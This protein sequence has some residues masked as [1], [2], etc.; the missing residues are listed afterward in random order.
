MLVCGGGVAVVAQVVAKRRRAAH[1]EAERE[2]DGVRRLAE[3]DT[4]LFGEEL[5]RLGERL[6]ER[7][8]DGDTRVDYQRALDAY[9]AAQRA[10]ALLRGPDEI[11]TV[12][13]ALATG[14]HAMACV[15]ARADGLPVPP[16]RTPCF[17]NPQHGPSV[18]DVEWTTS[19][20]GTRLVPACARDAA[21]V[22][23]HEKPE[24]RT[25]TIDGRRVPYWEAG[26]AFIPYSQGYFPGGALAI[27]TAMALEAR[28][29]TGGPGAFGM[30]VF[31]GGDFGGGDFGGGDFGGGDGF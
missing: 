13:D 21:R 19:R 31:G 23:A 5:M 24:V 9:E 14:R 2:L 26:A 25:V 4:V 3:E 8:I 16:L 6:G 17:F 22:A 27:D 7:E 20:H 11:S 18:R 1:D 12:T 15:Q 28:R 30:G 10:G 29:I